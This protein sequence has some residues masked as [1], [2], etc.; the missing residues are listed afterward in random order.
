MLRSAPGGEVGLA[1][2]PRVERLEPTCRLQKQR[3]S[4]AAEIQVQ[5]YVGAY[6]VCSRA[7]EL[8]EGSGLRRD[9]EP[10]CRAERAGLHARLRRRKRALR[11]SGRV[12]RQRDGALEE[13]RRRRDAAASLRAA[14]R[15]F[16][17]GGDV[18]VGARCARAR[19]QARRSG[20]V[21]ASVASARA[22]CTRWRSSR[23][24]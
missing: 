14:G 18:L 9:Q 16:E 11:A 22:R 6:Q 13:R 2:E 5:R 17:L 1:R 19:C 8:V 3:R 21:S 4:V 10:E 15:A 12:G 23:G 20:S 24:S 7:L